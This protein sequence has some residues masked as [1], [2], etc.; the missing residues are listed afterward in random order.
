[1]R[2]CRDRQ[3]GNSRQ[4]RANTMT[5]VVLLLSAAAIETE[6]QKRWGG[7]G[8]IGIPFPFPRFA[9]FVLAGVLKL[10]PFLLR[11]PAAP[12]DLTCRMLA[13]PATAL[14]L[15][16]PPAAPPFLDEDEFRGGE[17]L[18]R[19]IVGVAAPWSL[20]ASVRGLKALGTRMARGTCGTWSSCCC[21]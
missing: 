14:G 12:A 19:V 9:A 7:A 3:A 17:A 13:A 15:T 20:A 2:G 21:W 16:L 8:R 5:S 1:M 18:D 11:T 6:K 10:P 4:T